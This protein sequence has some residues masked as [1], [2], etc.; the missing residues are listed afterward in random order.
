MASWPDFQQ[1]KIGSEIKTPGDR[2]GSV[3][4]GPDTRPDVG[5]EERYNG[6]MT[7]SL[8]NISLAGDIST[9]QAWRI[10]KQI[11]NFSKFSQ[12]NVMT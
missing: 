2:T 11:I 4:A 7:M 9:S 1:G 12:D 10:F 5:A 3:L 8:T 6:L